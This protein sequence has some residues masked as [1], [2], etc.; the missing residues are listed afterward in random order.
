MPEH[1]DDSRAAYDHIPVLRDEVVR[2][3]APQPGATLVDGT[4]GLGGHAEAILEA[5]PAVRLIGIDRDEAALDRTKTRLARF[6]ERVSLLHGDYAGLDRLLDE[7][8]VDAVDGLL[9]DVGV[10]SLQ[11]D[12]PARGFSFRSD[13]PLDM[14]MDRSAGRSAAEWLASASQ[15]EIA[16]VLT[17]YGEER[18]A[19]RIARA[20][21]E[22]RQREAIETT[23]ALAEIIRGAVPAAYRHGRIDAATRTFQAIRIR[24]N[25]ELE[26]LEAG[27][28]TGFHRLTCGG[29]LAVI[30]FH[31]L[32][33]RIVKRFFRVAATDCIC[34]PE[35]PACV[36][37][38]RVEAEVLTK[39]PV[40]PSAGE[41]A[42]NPRARSAKL[43]AA[44]KV[45]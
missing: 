13:G 4:V 6:G 38:K 15:A 19:A 31:S 1:P 10:S 12:D 44:R 18:Y 16:D 14:R 23:A 24:V 42:A 35:L 17:K 39:R 28:R 32:E 7:V 33:D 27:L 5:E 11:L 20:I 36:C 21:D 26:A 41:A 37:D 45:V 2:V 9:L 22:A 30:S 25:G 43:R 3:L 34:P 29:I 40:M 8:G